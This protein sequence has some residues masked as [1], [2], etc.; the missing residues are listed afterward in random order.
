MEYLVKNLESSF[1]PLERNT[2]F[3]L[4][5]KY[6]QVKEDL[7]NKLRDASA[8]KAFRYTGKAPLIDEYDEFKKDP[9]QSKVPLNETIRFIDYIYSIKLV[10][11][12]TNFEYLG[13]IKDGNLT[14]NDIK[15]MIKIIE[16]V[17]NDEELE[18]ENFDDIAGAIGWL[19]E[20]IKASLTY[21]INHSDSIYDCSPEEFL[22][23]KN[24]MGNLFSLFKNTIIALRVG[25][26][27][28]DLYINAINGFFEFYSKTRFDYTTGGKVIAYI[29][30]KLFLDNIGDITNLL[31]EETK[32]KISI[33]N[34][35]FIEH[36]P[37]RVRMHLISIP[38]TIKP[39]SD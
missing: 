15:K 39:N 35:G 7:F 38:W 25:M 8:P 36:I 22:I 33:M 9:A 31:D 18:L 37:E 24:K 19:G 17:L 28:L 5:Q 13:L 2:G 4:S 23:D 29:I 10:W 27:R 11:L 34:Q 30:Y 26:P 3:L 14:I 1:S 20:Y 6:D 16:K 32:E 12:L 21:N